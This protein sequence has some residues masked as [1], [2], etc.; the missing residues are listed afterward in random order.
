MC[1]DNTDRPAFDP[2]LFPEDDCD[3]PADW[4]DADSLAPG[5]QA[6]VLAVLEDELVSIGLLAGRRARAD[7]APEAAAL[8]DIA[9]D[10]CRVGGAVWNRL[11]RGVRAAYAEGRR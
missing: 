8:W 11:W 9:P 1:R 7:G 5:E 6:H 2:D 10:G 4:P 3:D